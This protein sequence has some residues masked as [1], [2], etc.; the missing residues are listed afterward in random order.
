MLSPLCISAGR[1]TGVGSCEGAALRAP[2]FLFL[3]AD[4][5]RESSKVT[6]AARRGGGSVLT[7]GQVLLHHDAPLGGGRCGGRQGPL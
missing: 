1:E 5:L 2:E 3:T 6:R 7:S 4:R